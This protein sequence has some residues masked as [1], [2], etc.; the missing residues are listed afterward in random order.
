M[1]VMI[2]LTIS[3]DHR[4]FLSFGREEIIGSVILDISYFARFMVVVMVVSPDGHLIF[5]R[6]SHPSQR[7]SFIRTY[8]FSVS[9][10]SASF[11]AYRKSFS[12]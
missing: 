7:V 4:V 6:F 3:A 12:G 10:S 5:F 1:T 2:I 11:Q 8:Q 9:A